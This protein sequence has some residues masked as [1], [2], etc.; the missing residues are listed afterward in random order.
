VIDVEKI[1]RHALID[2]LPISRSVRLPC[3]ARKNNVG[4]MLSVPERRSSGSQALDMF[5]E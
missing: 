3:R 2:K 1:A 4:G 5:F